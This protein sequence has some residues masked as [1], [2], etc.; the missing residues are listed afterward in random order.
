MRYLGILLVAMVPFSI[1]HC[2]TTRPIE[3]GNGI[4]VAKEP[5]QSE[6]DDVAPIADGAFLLQP[7]AHFVA[8][9]RVLGR[10]RYHLG[11]FAD[12]APLDIAAGWGPMS[13]SAVLAGL[14]ISQGNRFYYWHYDDEPPI[15]RA[16]I[17]SHS[18][19]WHL[20]PANDSVWRSLRGVRVGEVVH[21][22]GMLIDISNPDFGVMRTSLSRDD[23]GAGACEIIYVQAVSVGEG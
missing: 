23:T 21:L 12:I 3:H 20:V 18:A 7:R 2:V 17:Q 4:L 6:P 15:P 8:D 22:E 11:K 5:A 1:H 13:D 16:A 19:N 14:D 10:E 9:A